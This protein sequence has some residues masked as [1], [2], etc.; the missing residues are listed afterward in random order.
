MFWSNIKACS[1]VS[2]C[3]GTRRVFDLKTINQM[4]FHTL[5][6]L[7]AFPRESVL[8]SW[9]QVGRSSNFWGDSVITSG[10]SKGYRAGRWQDSGVFCDTGSLSKER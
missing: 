4:L 1:N 9:F 10:L 2:L 3:L 7:L 5:S 6:M 8:A